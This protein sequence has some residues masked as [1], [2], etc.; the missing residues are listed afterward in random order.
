MYAPPGGLLAEVLAALTHHSPDGMVVVSPDGQF[1]YANARFAEIWRFPPE[2]LGVGEDSLA[3]EAATAMVRDPE[4]FLQAVHRAYA[5]GVPTHDSVEMLDGRV[6]DRHGVP[7]RDGAGAEL[8][9]AWYFRDVTELRRAEGQQRALADTLQAS[10]LPPRPPTVP[11]MDVATRYRPGDSD[12]LVGGDFFDV[13]RLGPNAWG[14]AVGDVCGKGAGP[15]SLTALTRYTLRAAA[16]HHALPSAVLDEVNAGLV[17]DAPV[18]ADD[19]FCTVVYARLE[20]DVCGAWVTLACAGHPRPIVVRRAGWI[21]LRGQAGTPVGMFDTATV[22]D[23]RVGLGPGDALLFCTDGITEARNAAGE[24][25]GDEALPSILLACA[26][27]TADVIAERVLDGANRFAGARARDDIA[28][29]VVRVPPDAKDNSIERLA[30]ATGVPADLLD[31]PGYPVG[32][33]HGGLWHQRPLAPREAR[34]A[35]PADVA[36]V[37]ATRQ[38][39]AGV[40]RSWRMPEVVEGDVQLLS[41][42]LASNAV[43]H[44]RSRFTVIVRY[45][46]ER[47]R[48]E[49]G[50]GSRA[51]PRKRSPEPDEVGGRGLVLVDVLASSWGVLP[52]LEGKRVWFEVPA[53]AP[54]G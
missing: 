50:D 20:L 33:P 34:I 31:L 48:V 49:V 6:L 37:P 40:L 52:T 4:A 1:V 43:R 36:S 27:E 44:A 26:G 16:V 13:F 24:E 5:S 41:S 17:A 29:L 28:V 47:L 8:G 21:D 14:L 42:E 54:R 12:L 32:D 38:F 53:P 10:L 3:L 25:F 30:A 18:E 45:D 51:M 7:L 11:G 15:A 39:L 46:G 19:R 22:T 23:D 9:W 35:L 2:V